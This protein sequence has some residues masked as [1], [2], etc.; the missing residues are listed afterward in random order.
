MVH[1]SF[2]KFLIT[3][4]GNPGPRYENTRHNIG[5]RVVD[6]LVADLGGEWKDERYGWVSEIRLRGR[7]LVVLKPSTFMNLSGKAV[8]HWGRKLKLQSPEQVL[9]VVD[10]I[11]LEFGT[12]RLRKKGSSGGHNGLQDIEEKMGR[13]DYPRLRVGVGNNFYSGQQIDYVLGEWSEEEVAGL[14]DIV[15]RSAEMIKSYVLA[16]ADQ[17]MSRYNG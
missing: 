4:L 17:T 7:S 16:G 3:G 8:S 5:F 6:H 14:V 9:V 12:C 2:K 15:D 11:H 1:M 13:R 10:D